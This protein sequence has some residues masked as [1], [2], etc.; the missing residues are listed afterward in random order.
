MH[1]QSTRASRTIGMDVVNRQGDTVGKVEDI[2]LDRNGNVYAIVST[3]TFLAVGERLHAV[4]WS[5]LESDASARRFVLDVDKDRL[6]RAP[7]FTANEYPNMNDSKWTAENRKHFPTSRTSSASAGSG[8]RTT[9]MDRSTT[10]GTGPYGTDV[11]KE[12]M[13]PRGSDT[14]SSTDPSSQKPASTGNP[15]YGTDVQK[16]RTQ[17]TGK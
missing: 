8:D 16:E 2:A 14:R 13:A 17:G 3:G 1:D 7:G 10:H 9:G 11:Q 12:R 15:P 6:G 5:A 4:P